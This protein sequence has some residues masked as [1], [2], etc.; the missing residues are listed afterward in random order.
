MKRLNDV[1]EQFLNTDDSLRA[2]PHL[3]PTTRKVSPEKVAFLID[4]LKLASKQ[5]GRIVTVLVALYVAMLIGGFVIVFTL[6]HDLKVMHSVLG[7]S[8]LSL[9]VILKSLQSVWREQTGFVLMISLLP[10]LS[11]E[12]AIKVVET[13]YYK[14]RLSRGS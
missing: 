10:S 7:G 8:Y 4:Q 2:G 3:G 11:T 9:L 5:N 13:H 6:Y 1:I 14:T 12:E